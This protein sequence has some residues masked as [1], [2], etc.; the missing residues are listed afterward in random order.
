MRWDLY[1]GGRVHRG[2]P[3]EQ[4]EEAVVI[5]M[6]PRARSDSM[7]R[8]RTDLGPQTGLADPRWQKFLSSANSIVPES[9]KA[10]SRHPIRVQ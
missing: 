7:R 8:K 6:D 5:Q 10:S 2:S 3:A 9:N 4:M 1:I